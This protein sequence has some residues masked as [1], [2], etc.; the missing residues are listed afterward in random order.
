[1]PDYILNDNKLVIIFIQIEYHQKYP[2][3]LENKLQWSKELYPKEQV[4]V[5]AVFSSHHLVGPPS[6]AMRD[7]QLRCFKAR[8]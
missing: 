3:H 1:M 7:V 6:E 8:C 4:I 2:Q 5:M